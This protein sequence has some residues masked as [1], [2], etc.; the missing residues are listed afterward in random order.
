MLACAVTM[1][2]SAGTASACILYGA[3]G[4]DA[5]LQG[6]CMPDASS[7]S[8]YAAAN[9]RATTGP[10]IVYYSVSDNEGREMSSGIQQVE[11]WVKGPRDTV[12]ARV[13]TDTSPPAF[14]GSDSF[15]YDPREGNGTYSFYT[16]ATDRLGHYEGAP[17]SP[18]AQTQLG[19]K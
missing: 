11:L 19:R 16:R 14:Y 17:A 4:T 5:G 6:P 13:D 15:N 1:L 18:D 10:I 2:L 8:S 7:P 12:F 9:A 3:P